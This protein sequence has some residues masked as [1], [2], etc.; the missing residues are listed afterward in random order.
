[1]KTRADTAPDG[2]DPKSVGRA[3]L[4]IARTAINEATS[5]QAEKSGFKSEIPQSSARLEQEGIAAQYARRV[6]EAHDA[7]VSRSLRT[8]LARYRT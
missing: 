4:L 6:L 5:A 1:L 7:S 3:I 2:G 8:L